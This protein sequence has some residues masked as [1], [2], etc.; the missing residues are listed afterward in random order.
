M[1]A[2][3]S[4]IYMADDDPDDRFFIRQAIHN[5]DPSVTIV[6]AEDGDQLLT[7]LDKLSQES[8]PHPVKLILLDMNMPRLNGLETL[9]ILK[10]NPAFQHIPTVMFSTSAHPAQVS[11]AYQKGINSYIQK[12]VS[13]LDLTPIAQ[14]LKVCFLTTSS[15]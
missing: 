6:E 9:Q 12:P 15:A 5:A 13:C 1:K 8:T 4:V 3:A 10:A 14:A 11:V 7:L 2:T